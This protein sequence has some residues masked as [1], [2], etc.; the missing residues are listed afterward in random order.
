MAR[1]PRLHYPGAYYHV[2]L[3][4]NG[5]M[6]IFYDQA[7]R[8][9]FFDLLEET[10]IRFEYRIHAFCLM[11][12]HVHFVMQVGE[13]SLSKIIQNISFRYTRYI[14]KKMERIGHLFQ[15]R[16]KA[17]LVTAD[18]Y[19][20]QLIRYIHLNPLRANMVVNLL[21]YP[22]SSHLAYL[23]CVKISWLTKQSVF[24]LLTHN[25]RR[26]T[27]SSLQFILNQSDDLEANFSLSM[28]KSFPEICDDQF[29]LRL[30]HLQRMEEFKIN[31]TLSKL[32]VLICEY[33]AIDEVDL[34]DKSRRQI[35]SKIRLIT[36]RLA[37]QYKLAN[38][39]EIAAYFNRD[40]STFS[41]GLS[42]W[43]ESTDVEFDAVRRF[44]EFATMQA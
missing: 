20:L 41:R 32:V 26:A 35:T 11:T 16:Y 43:S 29:M 31:L 18:D 15:G 3:R 25:K 36:A 6:Q 37:A 38:L 22:W 33:Y 19:L 5:G 44:I 42:R 23:G 17:Q 24:N 39:T 28:Q 8:E 27:A 34:H 4:G 21:D 40:V 13:S 10:V 7:D 30:T 14:N 12:N 2:M 9:K 1:K